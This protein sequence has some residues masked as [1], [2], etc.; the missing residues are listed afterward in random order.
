MKKESSVNGTGPNQF[1]FLLSNTFMVHNILL[2]AIFTPSANTWYNYVVTYDGSQTAAGTLCYVNGVKRTPT[3][4]GD[5]LNASSVSSAP[6]RL[7]SLNN[8]GSYF[9]GSLADAAIWNVVLTAGE[10]LA[11]SLGARPG[12]I[13][14]QNLLDWAPLD[15]TQSTEPELS[16]NKNTTTLT[17]TA[18]A[19]G[20][21]LMMFTPRW[22][23]NSVT[24]P[25]TGGGSSFKPWVAI[26]S[27]FINGGVAT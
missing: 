17:G 10:V 18:Y 25:S 12:L 16:G 13:R 21:P 3:I 6:L 11:L 24:V 26:N 15:G 2:Q 23:Q 1:S 8:T 27:N 7:S 20:P 5:S 14:P 9:A 22:A 4:T 19:A